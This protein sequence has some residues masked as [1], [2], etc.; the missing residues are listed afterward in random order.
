MV[1]PSLSWLAWLALGFACGSVPFGVLVARTRGIDLRA[2]G[3]K[4]IGAANV[5]RNLGKKLGALVLLLDAGKG[6]LPV[7]LAAH[8][9]D[10]P[11]LP[12]ACAFAAILGHCFTPWLGF[13]GGKGIATTLGVFLVID[14]VAIGIAVAVFA[15][16]VAVTRIVAVG[17]L[18]AA[19]ALPIAIAA[20]GRPRAELVLA[21]AALA[22]V[23]VL[24][25]DNLARL[26]AGRENR[27]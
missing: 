24:H 10:P 27:L 13:R 9:A 8:Q 5:T 12:Q 1:P 18:V 7:W 2:V 20:L 14:P 4:N 23:I 26:R 16:V 17:S 6:A 25:R 22:L 21:V 3:S 11:W 15:A 19:A